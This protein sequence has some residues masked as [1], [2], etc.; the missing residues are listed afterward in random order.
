VAIPIVMPK[1]AMAMQEGQVVDWL[2]AKGAWVDKSQPIMIVETEKVTHECEAPASGYF[3]PLV[4]FGVSVSVMTTVAW[5]ATTKEELAQ[6]EAGRLQAG[7][8]AG[9]EGLL[10]AETPGVSRPPPGGAKDPQRLKVAP[11]ARS[12][13]EQHHLDLRTIPGSGPDGRIVRADVEQALEARGQVAGE[14]SAVPEA[15]PSSDL[16][17]GMVDGKRI[18]A[19]IPLTGMRKAIAEHMLR[20]LAVSAQMS[21]MIEVDMSEMMSL[22]ELWLQKE[23]ETGVRISYTDLFVKIL[24]LAAQQVP[25]VNSSVIDQ[26]VMVWEDI[27]VGVTVALDLGAFETGLIV[28]VVRNADQMTLIDIS[29]TVRDLAERAQRGKLTPE[30]VTGGT[31]TLSNVGHIAKGWSVSTPILNQPQSVLVQPGGI[32]DRPVVRNGQIV[33]RPIM[34]LSITY[35][36]RVLDGMPMARFVESMQDLIEN[37]AFLAA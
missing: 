27:N 37:P 29:K 10:K 12:L 11:V 34:T 24:A 1:L 6:L 16:A 8:E 19:K 7:D 22:R 4:E 35:D 2:V 21:V 30:D 25:V 28:P 9:A 26:E 20:S 32:F 33:V 5:L 13:A 23:T 3:W 36:H 31:I 15:A 14:V 17:N 18:K